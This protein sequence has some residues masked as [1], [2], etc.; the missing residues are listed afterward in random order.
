MIPLLFSNNAQI[1]YPLS[2]FH[3]EDIPDDI[4]LDLSIN[5]PQ[6]YDPICAVLRIGPELFF[7]SVEEKTTREP[8]AHVLVTSPQAARVYPLEMEVDG[9]GW[10][11]LGPRVATGETFYTG[12]ISVELDP[13]T[14]TILNKSAPAFRVE[15]NGFIY[16][17]NTF[18]ELSSFSDLLLITVDGDTIYFDRNDTVL[19]VEDR[20]ALTSQGEDLV[21]I[22]ERILFTLDGIG[23]DASGNVDIDIDG[24]M[25]PCSND[26]SLPVPR[27]DT[28][29]G[30]QGELPLDIF[31]TRE[32][33]DGDP[34]DPEGDSS[35][36]G[37]ESSSTP[38]PFDGCT[39]IVKRDILDPASDTP[40]GTLYTV[41]R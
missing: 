17:L 36:S 30:E 26:K 37:P 5:V 25:P 32:Y 28:G 18:L 2:E 40:I 15:I 4:L 24:C 35:S 27:G 39:D 33:E 19:E 34:C 13:E 20:V 7:M 29:Q 38:D 41:D 21:G 9:F 12:D 1:K 14:T 22:E 3:T 31:N 23:P 8:I 16:D 6:G 10:V 11:T